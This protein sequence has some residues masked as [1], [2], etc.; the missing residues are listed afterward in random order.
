MMFW[1]LDLM[2]NLLVGT[3][4]NIRTSGILLKDTQLH[5][6]KT[7]PLNYF[8]IVLAKIKKVHSN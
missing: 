2:K 4:Q 7:F 5:Y 3:K 1:L 6:T 8:S